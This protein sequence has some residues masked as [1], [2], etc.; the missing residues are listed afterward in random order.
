MKASA[1]LVNQLIIQCNANASAGS[2]QL[3]IRHSSFHYV[4]W[5]TCRWTCCL[6]D[7]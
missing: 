2:T 1:E 7:L 6:L 3:H 5:M 4:L